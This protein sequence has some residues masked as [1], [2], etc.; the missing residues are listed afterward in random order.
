[1][2]CI[3]QWKKARSSSHLAALATASAMQKDLLSSQPGGALLHQICLKNIS[4]ACIWECWEA[5]PEELVRMAATLQ[6]Q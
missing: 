2:K 6:Q 1:M 3:S 5:L 4:R